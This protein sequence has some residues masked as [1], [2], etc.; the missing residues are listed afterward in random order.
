M[1]FLL[2]MI[3]GTVGVVMT[4]FNPMNHISTTDILLI[5]VVSAL[6]SISDKLGGIKE[7]IKSEK[8]KKVK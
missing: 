1:S 6:F 4:L 5:F 2:S 3:F 8:E 7:N